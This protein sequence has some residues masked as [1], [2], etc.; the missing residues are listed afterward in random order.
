MSDSRSSPTPWLFRVGMLVAGLSVAL[1]AF[2]AHGLESRLPVWYP[3]PAVAERRADNW[4]TAVLYQMVH[5]LGAVATSLLLLASS[6]RTTL[7]HMGLAHWGGV[8]LLLGNAI[9]SGCLYALVITDWK[10]LG[11]IVPIGGVIQL[12]GWLLVAIAGP[13]RAATRAGP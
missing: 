9:F 12:F 13:W 10:I 4:Q 1:G 7:A 2:G 6:R 8:C 11:A 3:D 5:A